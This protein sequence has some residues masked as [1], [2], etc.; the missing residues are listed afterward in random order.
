ML[1]AKPGLLPEDT[2]RSTLT[3]QAVANGDSNWF[4]SDLGRELATTA[5][6]E[7]VGHGRFFRDLTIKLTGA[8]R[9]APRRKWSR[10]RASG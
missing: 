8:R 1:P 7:A 10:V 3:G 4:S 2:A 5:R 9:L 6:G